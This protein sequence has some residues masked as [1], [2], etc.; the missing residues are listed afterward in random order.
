MNRVPSLLCRAAR[1]ASPPPAQPSASH[2]PCPGCRAAGASERAD[3]QEHAQG[4]GA[5]PAG[6]LG[7]AESG[8][9]AVSC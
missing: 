8:I 3:F 9:R 7:F 6:L 1:S 5:G 2:L 4:L